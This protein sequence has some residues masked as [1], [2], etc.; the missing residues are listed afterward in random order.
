MGKVFLF[1]K[2]E[3]QIAAGSVKKVGRIFLPTSA[4][5]FLLPDPNSLS[6]W[7]LES[8]AFQDRGL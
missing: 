7:P 1:G 3:T 5:T 6:L 8:E 2:V 4:L